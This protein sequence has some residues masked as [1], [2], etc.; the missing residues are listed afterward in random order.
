V[1]GAKHSA[2]S[3]NHLNDIDKTELNY[4]QSTQ[5]PKQPFMRTTD[6][7]TNYSKKTKAWIR[8]V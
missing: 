1:T 7:C 5:K 8:E 3:T 2:F 6:I 4:S